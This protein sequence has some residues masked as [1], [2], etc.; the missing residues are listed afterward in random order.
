MVEINTV[1][2]D[3]QTGKNVMVNDLSVGRY[4]VDI[5]T[6][7]SF[8]SQRQEA[9]E[10]LI[11]ILELM[12]NLAEEASDILLGLQDTS[13]SEELAKRVKEAKIR[14]GEIVPTQEE[15]EEMGIERDQ[16]IIDNARPQIEQELMA[17]DQARLMKAQVAALEGQAIE[18]QARAQTQGSTAQLNAKKG[19]AEIIK[20]QAALV[21]EQAQA[22]KTQADIQL[23][24]MNV[25]K[26]SVEAN[27]AYLDGLIKK[28]IDLGIP[29]TVIDDD[30]RIGQEDLIELSQMV[31]DPQ[32][33]SNQQAGQAQISNLEQ[34]ISARN[35]ATNNYTFDP[36]TGSINASS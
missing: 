13:G 29:L 2:R 9:S 30:N 36:R 11:K 34:V 3:A 7:P 35:Q 6:G 22:G 8:S 27:N 21:K 31:I 18:S 19:E 26:A 23:V 17:T 16:A 1:V 24:D 32:L 4:G 5:A 15:A 10:G 28:A 12:P 25:N 14:R 20:A 33:N